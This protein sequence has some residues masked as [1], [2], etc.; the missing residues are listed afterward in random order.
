[1][2]RRE[3]VCAPRRPR[4]RPLPKQRPRH[5]HRRRPVREAGGV[6]QGCL[7]CAVSVVEGDRGE[8][9]EVAQD[10]QD[11]GGVPGV[12]GGAGGVHH[13]QLKVRDL[14]P[15]VELGVLLQESV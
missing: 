7:P 2:E 15:E 3:P 1:M 9:E 14:A 13:G 12:P 8:G 6:V 10:G 11:G 4:V 5:L